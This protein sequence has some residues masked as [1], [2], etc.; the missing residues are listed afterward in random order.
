MIKSVIRC[1]NDMV[2]VFDEKDEQI[3]EYQG[4]YQEV[5]GRLLKDAPPDAGYTIR[6]PN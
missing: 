4:K 3:P 6:F 2:L 5:K 1:L